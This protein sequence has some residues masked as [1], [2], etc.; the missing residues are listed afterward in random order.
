Q[1]KG[2]LREFS[3]IDVPV[4]VE[5]SCE[6]GSKVEGSAYDISM[7]GLLMQVDQAPEVGTSCDL[8]IL[9][10]EHE[11]LTVDTHGEVVRKDKNGIGVNF[12]NMDLE[13]FSYMRNL[14]MYNAKNMEQVEQEFA[15]H[16]GLYRR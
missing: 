2:N 13:G 8:R 9:I 3:R 7:N 11:P 10:G 1:E 6:D 16:L 15:E 12:I 5:L 4:R 14:V